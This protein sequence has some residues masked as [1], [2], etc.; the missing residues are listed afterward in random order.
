MDTKKLKTL[1]KSAN[2]HL[3]TEP[4]ALV[5]GKPLTVNGVGLSLGENEYPQV[6]CLACEDVRRQNWQLK[7]ELYQYEERSEKMGETER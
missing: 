1:L 3:R 6:Q 2:L 4:L 5:S 7:Q